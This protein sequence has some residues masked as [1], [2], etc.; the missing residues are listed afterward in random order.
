MGQELETILNEMKEKG[1]NG[2]II[3]IDGTPEQS[4]VALSEIA[5]GL[6]ASVSNISDA[7]L[8]RMNDRQKELEVSFGEQILY[9]IPVKNHLFCG[10]IKD[11][12]EK[13]TVSEFAEK[14]KQ[15]L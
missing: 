12:E 4:T 15:Y 5:I 10:M 13:K 8:K 6:I 3:R 1:I 14:A 2:A 11:R 7:L 9:M